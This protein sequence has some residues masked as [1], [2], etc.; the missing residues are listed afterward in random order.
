[1]ITNSCHHMIAFRQYKYI[2]YEVHRSSNKTT[3]KYIFYI[4]QNVLFHILLGYQAMK[5]NTIELSSFGV[6][7]CSCKVK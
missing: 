5:N 7:K 6:C 1:M 2:N 3:I 4:N